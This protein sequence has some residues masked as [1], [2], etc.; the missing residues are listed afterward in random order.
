M[1]KAHQAEPPVLPFCLT[2]LQT[3]SAGRERCQDA[4]TP[5]PAEEATAKGCGRRAGFTHTHATRYAMPLV[6]GW[7]RDGERLGEPNQ[8][9]AAVSRVREV[10]TAN[11]L[12][13][14]QDV[15][16][17]ALPCKE[18]GGVAR[19]VCFEQALT[20]EESQVGQV[21]VNQGRGKCQ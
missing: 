2:L 1:R 3:A 5:L 20:T 8:L 15:R 6:D 21:S 12:A 10:T 4:V 14:V 18:G 16:D 19:L 13:Q 11:L 17:H 9:R 7:L